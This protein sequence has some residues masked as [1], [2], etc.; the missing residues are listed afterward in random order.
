MNQINPRSA[1][2]FGGAQFIIIGNVNAID[3][4]GVFGYVMQDQLWLGQSIHSGDREF[5]VPDH[6]PLEAAGFRVDA[7]GNKFIRVKGV[8]WFTNMDVPARHEHIPLY[9]KYSAN[10]YPLYDNYNAIEVSK[11]ADIP[12]DYDGIMGVPI[13][14]LDKYNPAQFEILGMCENKN[15][16]GLKTRQYTTAECREAYFSLFEKKG[17]YDLNAAG[18]ISGRKVYKRLLIR[19]RSQYEN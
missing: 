18:V 17:T 2:V 6:Y 7:N 16:F 1:R 19:K 10:E 9:K 8:R 12:H 13:T 4:R 14:F 15:L 11:V 3:Y 5:R